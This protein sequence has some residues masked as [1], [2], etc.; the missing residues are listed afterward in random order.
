[1]IDTSAAWGWVQLILPYFLG[2]TTLVVGVGIA[3]WVV[4]ILFRL[5]RNK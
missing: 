3:A 5:M 4:E 1:M 2:L